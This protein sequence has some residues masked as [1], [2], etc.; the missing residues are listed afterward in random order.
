MKPSREGIRRWRRD[1]ATA[2]VV[3]AMAAAARSA[4]AADANAAA[5]VERPYNVIL[6]ISD[7]E[8]YRLLSAAGYESRKSVV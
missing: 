2:L 4:T 8:Q 1:L 6:V 7:Q 3:L 5:A